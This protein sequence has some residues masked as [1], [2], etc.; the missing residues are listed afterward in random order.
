MYTDLCILLVST[1]LH[2]HLHTPP[3]LSPHSLPTLSH[4]SVWASIFFDFLFLC[5]VMRFYQNQWSVLKFLNWWEWFFYMNLKLSNSERTHVRAWQR[6][7]LC[8]IHLISILILVSLPW[9]TVTGN[10]TAYKISGRHNE[11]S[12]MI[13]ICDSVNIISIQ[14][15]GDLKSFKLLV[16]WTEF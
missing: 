14:S 6:V 2:V 5:T 9:Q 4:R 3:T 16:Y 11:L 10:T 8:P 1:H 15:K 7:V 13:K 12:N